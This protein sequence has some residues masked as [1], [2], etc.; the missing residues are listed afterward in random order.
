M[1]SWSMKWKEHVTPYGEE[2]HNRFSWE[3]LHSG[4]ETQVCR[5]LEKQAWM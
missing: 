2:M 3:N 5:P 4:K 1:K